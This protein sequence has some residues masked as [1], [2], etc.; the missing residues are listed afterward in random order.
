VNKR[1]VQEKREDSKGSG[2]KP[3]F[4]FR[5]SEKILRDAKVDPGMQRIMAFL[6]GDKPEP[7]EIF[8]GDFFRGDKPDDTGH[9]M[10]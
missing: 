1:K 4:P 6:N 10:E 9:K 7:E 2:G 8:K 3:S 5:S